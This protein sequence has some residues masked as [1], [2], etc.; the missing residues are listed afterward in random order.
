MCRTFLPCRYLTG[1]AEIGG[2]VSTGVSLVT[3]LWL[4][5]TKVYKYCFSSLNV[6]ISNI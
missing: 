5:P 1:F 2:Y 3:C 6:T 4:Q